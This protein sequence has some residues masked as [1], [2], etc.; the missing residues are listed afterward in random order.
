MATTLTSSLKKKVI[1]LTGGLGL[2]G[3]VFASNLLKMGAHVCILDLVQSIV[4]HELIE[5]EILNSTTENTIT[6]YK[7]DITHKKELEQV[8]NEIMSRFGGIDVLINNAALDPKVLNN[9]NQKNYSF[10]EMPLANWNNEIA[11]NLTG[12]MLCC[13]VFGSVM[14]ANSSVINIASIYGVV[15]PD[16]NIY[17]PGFTKPAAYGV[18]KAGVIQLTRYLAAYWGQ[19]QI[20][21]NCLVCGGVENNQTADFIKKYSTKTPLGRMAQASDFVGLLLYLASDQSSYTTGSVL[22]VDGGWTAV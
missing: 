19:K 21:V 5:S 7:A 3:K 9:D 1:I 10:E 16:Q 13:Q 22:T 11:V 20:R 12:T 15:A 17:P 6:Y 14:N 2:L 4:A 18:T 8:A